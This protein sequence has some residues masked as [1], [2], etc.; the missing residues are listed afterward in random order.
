MMPATTRRAS[1]TIRPPQGEY[2]PA[3]SSSIRPLPGPVAPAL[4][5][6]AGW[7][8]PSAYGPV[9]RTEGAHAVNPPLWAWIALILAVPVLASIDLLLFGRGEVAVPVRKAAVWCCRL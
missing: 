1:A 6:P 2:P 3:V 7:E 5:R 4:A 8:R 9:V